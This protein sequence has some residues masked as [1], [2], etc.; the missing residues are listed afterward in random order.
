MTDPASTSGARPVANDPAAGLPG[1]PGGSEST[2]R[3][4]TTSASGSFAIPQGSVIELGARIITGGYFVID[5]DARARTPFVPAASDGDEP[6]R[7]CF[8]YAGGGSSIGRELIEMIDGAR[9]KIF[10]GTL[11]MGDAA[12]REALVRAA[13]RLR[14]GVY[15]VSAL[16][17]KE[18]EKSINEVDDNTDI[19]TQLEYRNFRE[20]TRRGIYVRGYPGLHAKFVVVDDAIALVSSANLTTRSFNRVGENGVIVTADEDVHSLASLFGRLWQLSPWDLPPDPDREAVDSRS[21]PSSLI[22][23]PAPATG[24]TGPIWTWNS[25]H[26]HIA[27]AIRDVIDSAETDLVLATF[28]VANMTYRLPKG[29]LRP[30][31]LFEPVCRAIDRDVRVRMLLRGRNNVLAARAEAKA[32]AEAGVE[33]VPDRLNHAKGVIADG[34]RGALFSANFLTDYGLTGGM[35][36]GM[37]LDETPALVEAL[38][39]FEHAMVEANMSFVRNPRVDE[40]AGTL[41][42]EAL[43]RWPLAPTLEVVAADADWERLSQQQGIVL[44]EQSGDKPITLYSGRDRWKLEGV[45]GWSW[46]ESEPRDGKGQR[47]AD[48]FEAWL[49]RER[50]PEGVRRGICP[51]TFVRTVM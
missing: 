23:I 32:F 6:Y 4:N 27:T 49:T 47:A 36:V 40:L 51:A 45:E 42:A 50:T 1:R 29:G 37:R 39:Y 11:Y 44:Y 24:G 15:V 21:A 33:I 26:H 28:S 5:P 14:G 25:E 38:R 48:V 13:D 46:L 9:R 12:L 3:A 43:T 30:D 10:V 7:H 19:D 20:L 2:E 34:K 17:N 31:L 18:L 41:Y 16:N 22:T 8:T 35:E